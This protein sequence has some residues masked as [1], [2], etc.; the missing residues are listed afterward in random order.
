MRLLKLFILQRL[1]I[2]LDST[3]MALLSLIGTEKEIKLYINEM[4]KNP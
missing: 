3:V 4:M 1:K 2:L